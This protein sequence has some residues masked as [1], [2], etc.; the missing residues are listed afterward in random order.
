MNCR[1]VLLDSDRS[2]VGFALYLTWRVLDV[3]LQQ[4]FGRVINGY[5]P[6][7]ARCSCS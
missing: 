3:G 7:C 6:R 5:E 4:L 2:G 1:L